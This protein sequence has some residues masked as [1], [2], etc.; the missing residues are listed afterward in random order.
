M[1]RPAEAR[2]AMRFGL[3][4]TGYWAR[5]TRRKHWRKSPPSSSSAFGAAILDGRQKS[6]LL[7]V[8]GRSTT[9]TL[10]WKTS[11]RWPFHWIPTRGGAGHAAALA[12]K[13]LLL[14]KPIA[15]SVEAAV[16]LE[17]AVEQSSVCSVVFLTRRFEAAQRRWIDGLRRKAGGGALGPFGSRWVAAGE[18]VRI[19]SLRR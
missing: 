9:M 2:S 7:S 11:M 12:G 14:E 18:P 3:V 13:H 17:T 8:P 4:G 19:I 6:P 16:R 15:T 10:F 5:R 1:A